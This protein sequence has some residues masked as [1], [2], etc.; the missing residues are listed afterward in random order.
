MPAQTKVTKCPFLK[1]DTGRIMECLRHDCELWTER[2]TT[3][4]IR[5]EGCAFR[6]G[7]LTNSEGMIPV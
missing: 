1:A 5:W 6:L 7:A 2:Y 3:E 4:F